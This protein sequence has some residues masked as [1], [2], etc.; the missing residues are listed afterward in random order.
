VVEKNGD[1]MLQEKNWLL[2]TVTSYGIRLEKQLVGIAKEGQKA[3][4]KDLKSRGGCYQS[5][6]ASCD[7]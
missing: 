2:F 5:D 6:A 7:I 3:G 4:K 1:G